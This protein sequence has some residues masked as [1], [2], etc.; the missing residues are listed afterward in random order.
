MA[1][2][3]VP[4]P[5]RKEEIPYRD[6]T[7]YPKVYGKCYWGGGSPA[8]KHISQAVI[9][10]RNAFVEDYV[11]TGPAKPAPQYVRNA[12]ELLPKHWNDHIEYYTVRGGYVVMASP[13]GPHRAHEGCKP[14]YGWLEIPSMYSPDSRTI[15]GFVPGRGKQQRELLSL[16]NTALVQH[17][18]PLT[19]H[20]GV[21]F[22][23]A[24]Y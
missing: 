4:L 21:T 7:L 3:T 1:A 24:P 12:A 2:T 17:Q 11:I 15:I 20:V 18:P 19:E 13:Y 8:E 5:P 22:R 10:N 6:R 14:P 23:F 16:T 9:H